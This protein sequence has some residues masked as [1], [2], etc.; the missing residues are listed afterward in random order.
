MN[1]IKNLFQQYLNQVQSTYGINSPQYLDLEKEQKEAIRVLEKASPAEQEQYLSLIKELSNL[2]TKA[3]N[4]SSQEQQ[5]FISLGQEADEF[6][7]NLKAKQVKTQQQSRANVVLW[8]CGGV[9]GLSLITLITYLIIKHKKE[10]K[11]II[12]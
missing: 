3:P 9:V 8:V 2:L 12:W 4:L 11:T 5:R 7:E 10:K 6:I 1:T